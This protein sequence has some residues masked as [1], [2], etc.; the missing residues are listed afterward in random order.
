MAESDFLMLHVELLNNAW[1]I[2][3]MWISTTTAMI[4]A[5][6]FIAARIK[7]SLVVAMLSLYSIFTAACAAQVFR[8]WGRIIGIGEDLVLL[9]EGGAKL[10]HSAQILI[11]NLDSR[12]VVNAVLPLMLVVFLSSAFYVIYCYRGGGAN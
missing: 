5:A 11:V 1:S 6:Y 4:G 3:F 7:V 8:T 12:L 10:S 2:L 9:Q